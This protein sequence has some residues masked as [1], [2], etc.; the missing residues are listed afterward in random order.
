MYSVLYSTMRDHSSR[1]VFETPGLLSQISETSDKI[2][3]DKGTDHTCFG[4]KL[5]TR[6]KLL[7]TV[8]PLSSDYIVDRVVCLFY[9]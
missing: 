5:S 1:P 9:R 3:V 8:F 6:S 2:L 7:E 4:D